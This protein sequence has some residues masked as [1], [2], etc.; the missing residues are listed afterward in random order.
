MAHPSYNPNML[1]EID[2]PAEAFVGD[3][4]DFVR[5]EI[6]DRFKEHEESIRH[7]LHVLIA[8]ENRSQVRFLPSGYRNKKLSTEHI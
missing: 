1:A 3:T 5:G 8:L 6:P 4:L 2:L 7:R